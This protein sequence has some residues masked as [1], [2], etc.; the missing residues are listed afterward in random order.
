MLVWSEA[1][2]AKGEKGKTGCHFKHTPA[3]VDVPT[4][5]LS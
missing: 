5:F 4:T 2:N 3:G 1:R